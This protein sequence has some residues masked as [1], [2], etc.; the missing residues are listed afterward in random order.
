MAD[1]QY[2]QALDTMTKL[3]DRTRELEKRMVRLEAQTSAVRELAEHGAGGVDA[4]GDIFIAM[5]AG[6]V[7]AVDTMTSSIPSISSLGADCD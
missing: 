6:Q 1:T 5:L 4:L 7:Y 3:Y 2:E